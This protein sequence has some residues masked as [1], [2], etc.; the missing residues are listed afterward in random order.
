MRRNIINIFDRILLYFFLF[1]HN[2]IFFITVQSFAVVTSDMHIEQRYER[3]MNAFLHNDMQKR[4]KDFLC[5]MK[6]YN[7]FIFAE[8]YLKYRKKHGKVYTYQKESAKQISWR[9][10]LSDGKFP[11]NAVQLDETCTF[12]AFT[13]TLFSFFSSS[14]LIHFTDL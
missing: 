8:K 5:F 2:S 13:R 4:Q 3:K 1:I 12:F 9:T 6:P 7:N 14:F 10:A 11:L